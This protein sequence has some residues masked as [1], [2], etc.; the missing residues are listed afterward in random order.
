[1][2]FTIN[3]FLNV[4]EK[5]N[6]AIE[7]MQIIMYLLGI[8][9]VFLLFKK[10]RYSD[11][12]I[13]GILSF[14]WL[15][16]GIVYHITY[17]SSINRAAYIF[18]AVFIIQG[19]LLVYTGVVKNNLSFKP[20]NG[21]L[22]YIAGLFILYAMVIYPVIGYML[23]HS[24]PFSPCFGVAP[25]PTTIFTFGLLLF[26]AERKFPR[27]IL[28][29]PLIWS[30]IGFFAALNLGIKEDIGLLIAG[31][32]ATAVILIKRKRCKLISKYG[33]DSASG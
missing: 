31:I 4:F 2:P 23:G 16:M 22:A 12:I 32:S 10:S 20:V 13:S 26:A 17:F 30:A 33:A 21:F 28:I 6:K 1:M 25:C 15:W 7:P 29:L 8:A 5:Y 24:Y 3:E 9:A 27:H 18:G 19:L 14:M 11:K